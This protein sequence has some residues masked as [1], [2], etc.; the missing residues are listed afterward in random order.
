MQ[1]A[2][3]F[4]R[5]FTKLLGLRLFYFQYFVELPPPSRHIPEQCLSIFQFNGVYMASIS[6]SS[7]TIPSNLNILSQPPSPTSSLA[8]DATVVPSSSGQQG[9]GRMPRALR[10][11]IQTIMTRRN[12]DVR[13]KTKS[14]LESLPTEMLHLIF[15]SLSVGDVKNLRPAS[16]F[17]E[18]QASTSSVIKTLTITRKKDLSNAIAVYRDGGVKCM[19]IGF[20]GLSNQDLKIIGTGIPALES[21]VLA[22]SCD[23]NSYGFSHLTKVKSLILG[24]RPIQYGV[25]PSLAGL[26]ALENIT[27]SGANFIDN[28][29]LQPLAL[30]HQLKHLSLKSCA[31]AEGALSEL[32]PLV[33]LQSFELDNPEV[34][35]EDLVV[36]RDWKGLTK[37]SLKGCELLGDDTLG[38]LSQ[39]TALQHLDLANI[40]NFTDEGIAHLKNLHDLRYLNLHGPDD[41]ELSNPLTDAALAS[42]ENMTKLEELS[43]GHCE[44]I[45]GAGLHHLCKLTR[46]QTLDLNTTA[47]SAENA[48]QL[49]L[50][51]ALKDLNIASTSITS[52]SLDSISD[53]IQLTNIN[54]TDTCVSDITPLAKL[55]NL[56]ELILD[57]TRIENKNLEPLSG[58]SS[59]KILTLIHT[60][61]SDEGI[62]HINKLPRIEHLDMSETEISNSGLKNLK[63]L[64]SL[65]TFYARDTDISDKGIDHL[66]EM[67]WLKKLDLAA[68]KITD[69]ALPHLARLTSLE[70]LV[71]TGT[72]V[73]EEGIAQPQYQGLSD[74]RPLS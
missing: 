66:S 41:E 64:K 65:T 69:A 1:I 8:S 17:L 24:G 44:N 7:L 57:D 54:L 47:L 49:K 34:C 37:L 70:E 36:L 61:I 25:L 20:D 9:K 5:L 19:I 18:R 35:D 51:P 63:L 62:S 29:V 21:L 59:L 71:L 55:P 53:L 32:S 46:L 48:T 11:A 38:Y 52:E 56:F 30:L 73:S 60:A 2:Y 45:T 33:G 50:L 23:A 72:Q 4:E 40:G 42:F 15:H 67:T 16:R 26:Q 12:Q 22:G 10:E 27:I 74:L 6:G 43:L 3:F 58:F 31:F 68:T 14:P 28:V 13:A 39:L